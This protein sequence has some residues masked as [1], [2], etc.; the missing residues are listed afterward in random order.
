MMPQSTSSPARPVPFIDSARGH[1]RR[2]FCLVC[3]AWSWLLPVAGHAQANEEKRMCLK[4]HEEG[5]D[6]RKAAKLKDARARFARCAQSSCPGPVVADCT[7]WSTEIQQTIPTVVF[8][9]VG[10]DGK[11]TSR[12]KVL[13]DGAPLVER[14]DGKATEL[15][16]GEHS[17]QFEYEGKTKQEKHIIRE[18]ERNRILTVSFV[19]Q[20]ETPVVEPSSKP[21]VK[22]PL[23]EIPPEKKPAN[24]VPAKDAASPSAG[25]SSAPTFLLVT[26]LAG[27]GVGLATGAWAL[28][29]KNTVRDNCD[30]SARTCTN[31]EGKDAASLGSTVATISTVGTV[32]GLVGLG[33]WLFWP[34]SEKQSARLDGGPVA[35][36]G[37]LRWQGAWLTQ[38]TACP[39]FVV[40]PGR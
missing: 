9:G 7:Q 3:L 19:E 34:N 12:I 40:K 38:A 4:A 36:G 35:G 30:T 33:A 39:G 10:K 13:M 21:P 6:L 8:S 18:G 15:D 31:S 26:G 11:E 27:L 32:V 2:L 37:M 1:R 14:L 24:N 22:Q 25:S 23:T 28:S 29:L 16:P 17:F 20:A 5:Q